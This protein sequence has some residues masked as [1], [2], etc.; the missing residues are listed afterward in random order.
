MPGKAPTP[1]QIEQE[2][3]A[4]EFR[5]AGYGYVAIAEKLQLAGPG[6]SWKIVQRALKRIIKEPAEDVQ[7][8]ELTRLDDMLLGLWDRAKRGDP[9]SVDRVLRIQERRAELSGLDAPKKS[10]LTTPDGKDAAPAQVF[11]IKIDR[12]GDDE[13]A[14]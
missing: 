3:L 7:T 4:L 10:A 2:R 13:A 6:S 5:K 12:R 14:G 1:E 11:T 8:L 9:Y